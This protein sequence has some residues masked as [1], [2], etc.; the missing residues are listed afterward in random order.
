MAATLEYLD[1]YNT[2]GEDFLKFI[3]TGD[4]IWVQYDTPK[5]TITTTDAHK[6]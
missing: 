1:R 5:V 6:F 2:D 4:E 3:V